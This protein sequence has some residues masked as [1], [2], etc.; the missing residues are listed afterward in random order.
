MAILL[1]VVF[2][3][4]RYKDTINKYSQIYNLE[5]EVVCAV[6]NVES[7]FDKNAVSKVG[8][9]GLMQLMPDTATE[10]AS[11]LGVKNF[12]IEMLYSPE[13]NI[14]F[15]CYY[16]R[17]LL[18]MFDNNLTNALASYNAGF[19]KVTQ[20]LSNE[21][22]SSDGTIT[23]PPVRETKYYIRKIENNI[24]VYSTRI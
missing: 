1:L 4:I 12:S 8:A 13:I 2:Y 23:N 10:I 19:N 3:P 11:K 17:Y 22:Y 24:S 9:V 7:G 16:L 15:G 6:I 5:P 18:N 14:R 20:W 21:S